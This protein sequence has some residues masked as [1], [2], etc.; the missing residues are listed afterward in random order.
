MKELRQQIINWL[1]EGNENEAAKTMSLCDIEVLHYDTAFSLSGGPDC[2]VVDLAVKAPRNV[3]QKIGTDLKPV[4]DQIEN[5]I[6]ECLG[7]KSHLRSMTWAAQLRTNLN[8]SD[9]EIKQV[10]E[11]VD[12]DHIKE[13]WQ[14]S[15]ERRITDP[16]GA[17]TAARTLL[18]SVC[19]HILDEIA[20][21]YDDKT[22]LP[23]LYSM[24]ANEL[25]LGPNQHTEKV[26]KQ[27]LGG[28]QSVVEG[29]GSLRNKLSDAHGKGKAGIRPA[30][31][32]AELAVNL[33]GT[34][35]TFLIATW[36]ARKKP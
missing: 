21:T 3:L 6:R 4:S 19:K 20:V 8:P 2:E 27:I 7:P 28:C 33:A 15:I 25:N 9:N 14:K 5:A 36:E 31:R 30:P 17:I 35:A 26:F 16:E 11:K 1:R 22:D 10:L 24:V 13:A 29:L 23:K 12:S 32:H 18:E 34:M